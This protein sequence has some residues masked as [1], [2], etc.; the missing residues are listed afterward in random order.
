M[1]TNFKIILNFLE[2]LLREKQRCVKEVYGRGAVQDYIRYFRHHIDPLGFFIAI[3]KNR[4]PLLRRNVPEYYRIEPVNMLLQLLFSAA[5]AYHFRDV[6]LV[7]SFTQFP[8]EIVNGFPPVYQ[9]HI[10]GLKFLPVEISEYG[11]QGKRECE[12]QQQYYK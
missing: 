11:Y 3:F 10:K 8:P 9:Q 2:E 4:I 7:L 12:L 6:E 5:C 1:K